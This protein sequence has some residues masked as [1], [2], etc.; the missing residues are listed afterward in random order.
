[1][2][3]KLYGTNHLSVAYC[4]YSIGMIHVNSGTRIRALQEALNIASKSP[5]GLTLMAKIQ[6][7]LHRFEMSF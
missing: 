1:M 3:T 4:L 7:G 5:K 6:D 2:R